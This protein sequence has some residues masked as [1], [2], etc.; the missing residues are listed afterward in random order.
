MSL[1]P[2]SFAPNTELSPLESTLQL[3]TVTGKEIKAFGRKTVQLVGRELSFSISFVVA[4]VEHALLGLDVLL[5]EQLSIVM[6]N[7]G[8][9]NLVNTAGA[10]TQLQNKGHLLYLGAWPMDSGFEL[11]NGVAYHN[12]ME[13]YSMTRVELTKMQLCNMSLTTR[14]F[15]LQGEQMD[16]ASLWRILGSI[17]TQHL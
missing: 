17:R 1:A 13:A 2:V 8:E 5:R 14:G 3:R 11:A 16:P 7:N 15:H 10:K 6:S 9:I 12:I 4:D